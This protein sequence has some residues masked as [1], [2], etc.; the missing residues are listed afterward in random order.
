MRKSGNDSEFALAFSVKSAEF[1]AK[2]LQTVLRRFLAENA[3]R[4][5]NK[6]R[7]LHRLEWV[8]SKYF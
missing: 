5:L 1:T 3:E 2:T 7:V 8:F 6:F 4:D